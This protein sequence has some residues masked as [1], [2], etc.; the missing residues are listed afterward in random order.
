MSVDYEDFSWSFESTSETE[1]Q[2][3]KDGDVKEG[4]D[5]PQLRCRSVRK[6]RKTLKARESQETLTS[7]LKSKYNQEFII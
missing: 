5:V 2:P 1:L 4:D 7:Q 3:E 6:K